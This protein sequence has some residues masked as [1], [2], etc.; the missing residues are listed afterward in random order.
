MLQARP[1]SRPT[2]RGEKCVFRFWTQNCGSLNG[3]T[4]KRIHS[5]DVQVVTGTTARHLQASGQVLR[6][7]DLMSHVDS[8]IGLVVN[9]T[10]YQIRGYVD[11]NAQLD[12]LIA[13]LSGGTVA[14]TPANSGWLGPAEGLKKESTEF[15]KSRPSSDDD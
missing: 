11:L 9:V 2:Y 7:A 3:G 8:L 1:L 13:N 4:P 14:T 15:Y 10:S 6:Y 5:L 12:W